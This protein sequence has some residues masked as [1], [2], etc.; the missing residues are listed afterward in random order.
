LKQNQFLPLYPQDLTVRIDEMIANG[1]AKKLNLTDVQ[2]IV[3]MLADTNAARKG[4]YISGKD[5][6]YAGETMPQLP[7]FYENK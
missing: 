2:S 6:W 3:E 4:D 1:Q 7:F 5:K